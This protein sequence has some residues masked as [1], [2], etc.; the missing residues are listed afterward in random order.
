MEPFLTQIATAVAETL[1]C[2]VEKVRA[3]VQPSGNPERGDLSLPCFPL[4]AATGNPGKDGAMA[5]AQ[6]IGAI[7]LA[8]V[9]FEASGPFVNIRLAPEAVAREVLSAVWTKTPYGGS[10]EGKGKTIVIDFS[11]PNIA[12]PFH[13]GHLRSTVIGWSLGQLYRTLGY[14]VVGVNHLGDW[15]TQFG[16]MIAAW[17]RWKD[18]AEQRVKDGE[19]EIEVFADLYVRI[20]SAAKEDPTVRAEAQAWFKKLEDGDPEARELWTYFVERSKKEFL[21]VYGIL[22]IKHESDAGEAFYNDKMSAMVEHLK[23]SGLLVDG[24]T[25]TETAE[26]KIATAKARRSTAQKKLAESEAKLAKLEGKKLAK[27]QKK[28]DKLAASI[29]ALEKAVTGVFMPSDDDGSRPQG[30]DLGK[31][32]FAILL[33]SDGGT[34]YTTR[35]L[36]A[37]FYRK[38]TYDPHKVLY[39]VGNSQRDHF[40][41]WFQIVKKME[42]DAPWADGLEHVGFGNYLGMSTR[43][44]TAVFLNEVLEKGRVKA[45]EMGEQATKKVELTAEETET[46]ARAIG[47]GGLKFFDLKSERTKDIDLSVCAVCLH[48]PPILGCGI[49]QP[50]LD[51]GKQ[52]PGAH[53]L[54]WDRLLNLKGDSGPYLQFAYARLAG[55]LRRYGEKV[56]FEAADTALLTEP[57]SQALLKAI[58]EFPGKVK[59]AANANEPSVIARFVIELSQKTHSFVHHHRVIDAAPSDEQAA[60]GATAETLRATRVLLVTCAK[61]VIAEALDLLGIEALERM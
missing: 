50:C 34:T 39:V 26:R 45:K 13:L 57:E 8:D 12:K 46:V 30:V 10:D 44:G 7:E 1:A 22:G 21:R 19:I 40:L 36:T 59:Q 47:T 20:N 23:A 16:F 14:T 18:E 4:A 55:I 25:K 5:V 48:N 28:R 52:D 41:P 33:K 58:G 42:P 15:G 27:E 24:E 29:P 51:D 11:S 35:D 9:S 17:K 32:Q 2:D 56:S 54:D 3:S 61:K 43:K 38:T 37:A 6:K 53:V 60:A 49:C 31:G